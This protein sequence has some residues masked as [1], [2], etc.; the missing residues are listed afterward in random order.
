MDQ[1][2]LRRAWLDAPANRLCAWEVAK[3]LGLREASKD[4]HS[5]N[6]NLP[7]IAA[8]VA[9][10][11]GG[12]P[13]RSALHQLFDKIDVD[14]EWFPG[15]KWHE[16][17]TKPLLTEA[18]RRCIAASAMAVKTNSGQE[19]VVDAIILACPVAA[20]DEACYRETLLWQEHS[21]GFS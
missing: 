4:I 3:A 18:K 21:N 9:K 1:E 8:R 14:P 7:W 17:R 16:T 2:A 12:N 5:G 6:V 10:V 15:K 20:V 11:D 19:P 13:S